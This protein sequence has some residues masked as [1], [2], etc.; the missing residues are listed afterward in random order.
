V[1][2]ASESAAAGAFLS[3]ADDGAMA[4]NKLLLPSAATASAGRLLLLHNG[5]AQ[6]TSGAAVVPPGYTVL[7]VHD[8]TAWQDLRVI[9]AAVTRLQGVTSLTEAA[10]FDSG[11]QAF[12]ARVLLAGGAPLWSCCCVWLWRAAHCCTG[13][14]VGCCYWRNYC[15]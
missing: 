9:D 11:D 8:S 14:D 2:D 7:F 15:A 4:A 3:I 12:R 6:A 5:D 13:A 1:N 10:D